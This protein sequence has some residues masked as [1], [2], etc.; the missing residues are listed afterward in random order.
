[1]LLNNFSE[2][3]YEA[4]IDEAG[5]GSLA[6]PVT[7]AAVIFDKDLNDGKIIDQPVNQIRA[8]CLDIVKENPGRDEFITV[9]LPEAL[10]ENNEDCKNNGRCIGTSD[11]G[12]QFPFKR[13]EKCSSDFKQGSEGICD[14]WIVNK[15]AKEL[16]DAGCLKVKKNSKGNNVRDWDT[17]NKNCFNRRLN[18]K[19]L[20]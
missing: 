5:R 1:M 12:L 10:D 3:K 15:C 20:W 19:G 8:C 14:N 2:F 7:A 13:E 18:N 4:G 9:K 6:G 16:Y 11:L 17:E